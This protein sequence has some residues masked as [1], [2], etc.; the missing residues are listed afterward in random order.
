MIAG[1]LVTVT[2]LARH[3]CCRRRRQQHHKHEQTLE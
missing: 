2:V 1:G 3:L